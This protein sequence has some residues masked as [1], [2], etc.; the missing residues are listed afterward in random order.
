MPP[1]ALLD[2]STSQRLAAAINDAGEGALSKG[3]KV[4]GV[5]CANVRALLSGPCACRLPVWV[6][7]VQHTVAPQAQLMCK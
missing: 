7:L 6:H 4:G 1:K 5:A 3:T 2:K